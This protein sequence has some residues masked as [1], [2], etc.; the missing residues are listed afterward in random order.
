MAFSN[1]KLVS[2]IGKRLALQARPNKDFLV[3]S[4]RQAGSALS[5]LDQSSSLEPVIKPLINSL[6]KH[7]LIQ[8]KDKDVRLLVA[9]CINEI[10]RVL[11]PEPPFSD[12]IFRD[13][14]K[15]FASMFAELGDV[16]SPYFSRRVKILETV[17]TLKCCI[18][19]LDIGCDDI[20]Y[21]MFKTFFSVVREH[22]QQSLVNAMLSIMTLIL[23]EKVSQPLLDLILF[24]LLK[25]GKGAPPASHRLAV[26]IIQDC[27]ESLEPFVRGFLTSCILDRD[28]VRDELKEYYQELIFEI[29]QCAP[30]M[31]LAVIPNLSQELLTD[32]VDVRI[33]AVNLIGKLF[34][35]PEHHAAQEYRHLFVE[36]LKRFSD[37]STEVRI[38]ALECVK[39]C[40]IANPSKAESLEVLNAL[41]GRLLDFDDRVR[42][43]AVIVACDLARSSLKFIPPELI[44]R[45]SERL[46]D[47]KI[48]VRKIALKKLLEVYRDYCT[49]CSDGLMTLNDHLEQIP[50]RILMLCYDKDCKEFR[51][52]NMELVVA[53]D[54]FAPSLS[55]EERTRHWISLFSLFTPLHMKALTTILSQK[56]R[57]QSEMQNYVFLREKEKEN[58][59]EEV[60]ERFK[61]SFTKM[62]ASFR[63]PSK[64]EECFVKLNQMKDNSIFSALLELLDEATTINAQNTRDKFLKLI[65]DRHPNI[66][67][68]QSLSLKC[69]FNI[70]SSE[71][72]R[73]ILDN[74][75]AKRLQKKGL[76]ASSIDLLLAIISIYPSL[77]RGSE[78]QFSMLLLE[79][80]KPFSDK[81]LQI[82]AKAGPHISIDLS[83]IYPSLERVCLEGTRAQAKLAVSAVAALAGTSEKFVFSELCKQLMDALHSGRNIPTVLQSLGCIAQN[84]ISVYETREGEI[85]QFM[86]EKIFQTVEV[87]P[88]DG[89]TSFDDTSR[90]R[91]LYKLKIYA[92]KTLVKS[93]LPH[94]GTHIRFQIN[95]MFD[96]LSK[97]LQKGD[98]ADCVSSCESDKANIRIAAA[99][100]VLRLSRRWDLHITP[101]IFNLTILTA[102]DSS[103]FVRRLFLDKTHKLLKERAIPIRYACAFAFSASDCLKDLEDD[104]LKYMAEFIRDYSK[105]ARIHQVSIGGGGLMTDYPAYIVVFL[106]HVLAQ[107]SGFPPEDCQDEEIYALFCRPL[108][109][110]L[111]A[112]MNT[113]FVNGDMG[114]VNDTFSYL[115][116]IFRAVKRAEDAVDAQ[117]THKL[118]ILSDIGVEMVNTLNPRGTSSSHNHGKILLPSSLYKISPAKKC[119]EAFDAD[120]VKKIVQLSLSPLPPPA[121]HGRKCQEVISN[122][123]LVSGKEA[124]KTVRKEFHTK[125]KQDLDK[126]YNVNERHKGAMASSE[127]TILE[128]DQI[129]SSC[130]SMTPKTSEYSQVSTQK[131][132]LIDF[133]SLE[134]NRASDLV[135]LSST[136]SRDHCSSQVLL[137]KSEALNG[138]RIR[139]SSPIEKS[140]EGELSTLGCLNDNTDASKDPA[141]KCQEV[142]NNRGAKISKKMVS[143]QAKGKKGRNVSLDTSVSEVV[144]V[145][146][147]AIARRTRRRKL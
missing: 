123:D 82:L 104:A 134:E 17:A 145:N 57:L 81:L 116:S 43:Q 52:Q 18:L 98:I 111:K 122:S 13:I 20:V 95:E 138:E 5:E 77:L 11:A 97:M 136:E 46:R 140:D 8:N 37:K 100:S 14:F 109:F 71:H 103:S 56:R 113:S 78:K 127:S 10:M 66:E 121:K 119:D 2:D 143:L 27:S 84:S 31:L 58:N 30:Q 87:D 125:A 133:A 33:K 16:E 96:I 73:C 146:E 135:N 48:S 45:T 86:Y 4:L 51:P 50:C 137:H 23:K 26:S 36:F 61:T 99:K 141:A 39:A 22:H 120:L 44:S 47:K 38:A 83:D 130:G 1:E 69:M 9:I 79:D 63:D 3:K 132:K 92:L 75:S 90:C 62:S 89:L 144:D 55:V 53:G 7:G 124:Q 35:L 28:A 114:L 85:M 131:V 76:E 88:P 118:H 34:A 40:Y 112:L 91:G 65:G 126:S 74:L 108:I 107:D 64:A 72:V 115:V 117:T 67:F 54:L 15:L 21:E 70:F 93:F 49:K 29:F 12:E 24:N 25:E 60:L 41:E 106:I 59:S 68:F 42:T 102:K 6:V 129:S 110:L 147:D 19:M 142:T 80:D 105:E 128:N 139:L 101:Q 94:R 32:Q